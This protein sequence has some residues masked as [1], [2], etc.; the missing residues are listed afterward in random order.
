MVLLQSCFLHI[1]A[2]LSCYQWLTK[3]KLRRLFLNYQEQWLWKHPLSG[4]WF[5]KDERHKVA[6]LKACSDL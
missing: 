5:C 6:V 1:A 3:V 4:M 2:S